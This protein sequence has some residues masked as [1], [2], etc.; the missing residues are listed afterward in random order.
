[1]KTK[2]CIKCNIEKP[3]SEYYK[4]SKNKDLHQ[5]KC[6]ICHNKQNK[7]Y[8]NKRN[9]I[10]KIKPDNYKGYDTY[11]NDQGVVCCTNFDPYN[12]GARAQNTITPLRGIEVRE[13]FKIN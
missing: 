7:E 6:R 2:T 12:L 13:R 11:T 8:R 9:K 10:T 1:M 4:T 3:L 5:G